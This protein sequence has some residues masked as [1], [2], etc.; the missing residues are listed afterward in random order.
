IAGLD[1]VLLLQHVWAKIPAAEQPH[2]D[3]RATG[4]EGLLAL[5]GGE[6]RLARILFR[7]DAAEARHAEQIHR[8]SG[9]LLSAQASLRCGVEEPV[10]AEITRLRV[11]GGGVVR[12]ARAHDAELV[13]VVAA[14][15]LHPE[16]ILVGLPN[17]AA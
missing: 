4:A 17:I 15:V 1:P 9:R 12:V 10:A 8:R 5:H 13:R 11:G 16:A 14:G 7:P 6:D 2:L 3:A